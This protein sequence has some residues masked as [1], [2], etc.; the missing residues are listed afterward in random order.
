M[1][2]PDVSTTEQHIQLAY[3]STVAITN[4]AQGSITAVPKVLN[5]P[6]WFSETQKHIDEMQ[7]LSN[8]WL[9]EICPDSR[10]AIPFAIADFNDT[11]ASASSKI[12]EVL[13]QIEN[14]PGEIPTDSQKSSVDEQT[15]ILN[16]GV[17]QA[18]AAVSDLKKQIADFFTKLENSHST[19]SNDLDYAAGKFM[20]GKKWIQE[21]SACI[22]EHYLTSQ[23]MGPCISIVEIDMNISIK[24]QEFGANP[25][26]ITLVYIQAILK[27]QTSRQASISDAVENILDLWTTLATK[28]EAVKKDLDNAEGKDYT[29]ILKQI[30]FEVAQTQWQQVTDFAKKIYG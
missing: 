24:V 19:L 18:I 21:L 9:K 14:Q 10:E 12:L 25:T 1:L 16:K 3:D 7:A 29:D 17:D 4:Y 27:D 5:P 20:E 28:L 6:S 15:A 30:D 23:V 26:I 8:S 13:T 22:G 11:F 2:N